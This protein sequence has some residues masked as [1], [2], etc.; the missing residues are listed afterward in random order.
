MSLELLRYLSGTRNSDHQPKHFLDYYP[1]NQNPNRNQN[2][3]L[4]APWLS[5]EKPEPSI[6]WYPSAGS[7]FRGLMFLSQAYAQMNPATE[8]ETLFPDMFLFS[9]YYPWNHSHFLDTHH[10]YDDGRTRV[11][12]RDIQEF[13]PLRNMNL[14]RQ[15]VDFPERTLHLGRVIFLDIEIES[16]QLGTIRRPVIY[17]FAQNEAFCSQILLPCKSRIS[18]M[19]HVRYGGGLGGGGKASGSWLTA[20][21]GRLETRVLV[22]DGL[23]RMEHHQSGDEAALRLYPNPFAGFRVQ[24]PGAQEFPGAG[25]RTPVPHNP[26]HSRQ[27][28]VEP[29]RCQLVRSGGFP[30]TQYPLKRVQGYLAL[31]IDGYDYLL[32]SGYP[33]GYSSQ[34]SLVLDGQGHLLLPM[35]RRP[36]FAPGIL[37]EIMGIPVEGII[38]VEVLMAYDMILDLRAGKLTLGQN[39]DL[40]GEPVAFRADRRGWQYYPTLQVP[41]DGRSLDLLWDTGAPMGYLKSSILPER[42]YDG[43]FCDFVGMLAR[44]QHTEYWIERFAWWPRSACRSQHWTFVSMQASSMKQ[45]A[46]CSPD[47]DSPTAT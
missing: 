4:L 10:I 24:D 31:E 6:A 20:V 26:H 41:V 18:H 43:H 27:P 13:P 9:D 8:P 30:M 22:V 23:D 38:G 40:P 47:W 45:W 36:G 2:R 21:M 19:I 39:L 16:R 3:N 42:M 44:W 46:N 15:I 37:S 17:V 32:D 5:G 28:V 34:D 12:V 33:D 11:Q 35:E 1:W 7:D 14:D 29:R 25:T